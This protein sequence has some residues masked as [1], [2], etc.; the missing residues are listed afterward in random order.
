MWD[1]QDM[2]RRYRTELTSFLRRRVSSPEVAADLTQEAFL[3]LW[4]ARPDKPVVDGRA[5]LFR[6]AANLAINHNRRERILHFVADPDAAFDV[7]ADDAPSPERVV[8]SRQ[9]LGIIY[10]TLCEFSPTQ[11]AVF[12]L[13][14]LDGKTFVEIGRLLDIPPQTAFGHMSRMLARMQ[15]RLGRVGD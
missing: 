13:S 12:M 2:F 9:E 7:L 1:I 8:L 15:L 4:T 3:A 6:T 10:R 11:R 5:Y 14:R